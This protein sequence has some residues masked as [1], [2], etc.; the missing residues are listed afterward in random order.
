[1]EKCVLKISLPDEILAEIYKNKQLR[2]KQ[3]IED[4]VVDLIDYALKL[5]YYFM[6]FDWEKAEDEANHEIFLGETK[7]FDYGG[8]VCP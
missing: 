6:N 7:S 5:P 3:T 8:Q 4:V 2:H 1:M